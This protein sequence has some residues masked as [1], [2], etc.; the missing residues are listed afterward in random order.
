MEK[1]IAGIV[2]LSNEDKVSTLSSLQKSK[3]G[4][5]VL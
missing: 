5:L 2:L 4:I 3:Y 1:I